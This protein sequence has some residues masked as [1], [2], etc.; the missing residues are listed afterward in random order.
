[1]SADGGAARDAVG[2]LK[3]AER[4]CDLAAHLA[5]GSQL[6]AAQHAAETARADVSRAI[7]LL[8]KA[9]PRR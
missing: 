2:H 8:R 4:M 5:E 6:W 9:Q 3:K 7:R 1:M